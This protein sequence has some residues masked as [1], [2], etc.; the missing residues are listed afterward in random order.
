MSFMDR[1]APDRTHNETRSACA[2]VREYAGSTPSQAMAALL[3]S[4]VAGYL[5]ELAHAKPERV[6]PLQ[7]VLAQLQALYGVITGEPDAGTQV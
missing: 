2:L 5:L 1:D 3:A 7:L 6:A 4:M